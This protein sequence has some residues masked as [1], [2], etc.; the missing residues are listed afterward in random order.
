MAGDKKL[1]EGKYLMYQGKPL[2]REDNTI[3]Y[4]DLN[5]DP[6]V[7]VLEVMSYTGEGDAKT[8]DTVIIQIVDSKDPN[9]ILKQGKKNGMH[10]AFE[11]GMIW[12][13]LELKKNA[14]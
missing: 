12:L 1:V 5:N 8:P 7:M 10:A 2:V 14:Q 3:I 11:M 6:C 4:G 9:K 13:D